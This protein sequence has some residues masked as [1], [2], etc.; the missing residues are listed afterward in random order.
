MHNYSTE[1]KVV[2]T[3][4]NGKTLY[5]KTFA[6]L[7][8][9]VRSGEWCKVVE[10]DNP[11]SAISCDLYRV[12]GEGQI[13]HI[14]VRDFTIGAAGYTNCLTITPFDSYTIVIATV[15]YTKTTDTPTI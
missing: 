12:G 4:I 2:G 15:Q 1:E 5:E 6:N 8:I 7:S 3:W 9:D 14:G 13:V 11:E 10:L